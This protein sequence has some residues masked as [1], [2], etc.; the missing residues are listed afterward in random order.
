LIALT[1]ERLLDCSHYRETP[2]CSHYRETSDCSHY[3]ETSNCSHYRETSDCS[4]YRETLIA[5][6]TERLLIA[7]TTERLLIALTTERLLIA[8][9]PLTDFYGRTPT[10]GLTSSYFIVLRLWMLPILTCCCHCRQ[11]LVA[12]TTERLLGCCHYRQTLVAHSNCCCHCRQTLVALT[13]ERLLGCCHYRQTSDALTTERLQ[14][15]SLLR[16][17]D[18]W[19]S[20][21]ATLCAHAFH[22]CGLDNIIG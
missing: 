4:H 22:S 16:D 8:A 5:L 7:L 6:T 9:I 15:L 14:F 13:T 3:R 17:F 12:L 10:D 20:C 2:D 19:L 11:T 1:T 18:C 21:V